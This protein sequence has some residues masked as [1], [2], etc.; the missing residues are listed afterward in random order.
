MKQGIHRRVSGGRVISAALALVLGSVSG[1]AFGA[2]QAAGKSEPYASLIFL[3]ANVVTMNPQQPNA[4]ALAVN[5]GKI[6]KL[7]TDAEMKPLVGPSTQLVYAQGMTI[8]PGFIDPH[9]HMAGYS[10]YN[11]PENWLDVSSINI[12]FKPSPGDPRCATPNDPQQCFIPVQNHDEVLARITARVAQWKQEKRSGPVLAFNY[13]PSRLGHSPSCKKPPQDVAFQCPNF[14]DG[15]ARKQLDAI[16]TDIPIYVTSESGHIS[17]VNS[18]ALEMLNICNPGTVQPQPCHMPT[19]NPKQE[20][21]LAQM[22]QLN[23]DR[24]LVATAYFQGVLIKQ[25]KGVDF[26][27][28]LLQQAADIY[29]Q[30]GYTLAQEGAAGFDVMALYAQQLLDWKRSDFPVAAAMIAYDAAAA[31][32]SKTVETGLAARKLIGEKNPLLSVEA[33]KSFTDGSAQGYTADLKQPYEEWFKPYT[34]PL[35]YSQPYKGLPDISQQQ[36]AERLK[37]SHQAGFPMIIHQIG[38]QAIQNAV[39]ALQ[40][41][42]PTSPPPSGKRDVLLHAPMI[43]TQDLDTLK[44]LGNTMVS[45]MSSNV[46]YYALPECHQVLGPKRTLTIYP[47]RDVLRHTGRLTLHSDSPVTPPY[48]LFEI[49]TAVTRNAQQMPWYPKD[50]KC[51]PVM[52]DAADPVGGDQRISILEGLRAFTVD[53]AY[54]YGMDKTRGTIEIGKYAD[55]VLLSADPLAAEVTRDPNLLRDIRVIGTASYGRYFPNPNGYQ[56]PIWPE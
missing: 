21:A 27:G 38:D 26:S 50:Q 54:Q 39:N 10:I 22:G 48:P 14:E 11:D 36:I 41:T 13:D 40:E 47:S 34:E 49:W 9:S 32:F 43:T 7:G 8:L 44:S 17:Y 28:K 12:Y 42:R 5:D 55:L 51:P 46:Y 2:A 23:E 18:P 16:S 31:D 35:L 30:H 6:V 37:A 25:N 3:N 29:A 15:S 33:L 4:Q 45:E 20:I 52:V 53:A 56:K 1:S 24:S 19:T